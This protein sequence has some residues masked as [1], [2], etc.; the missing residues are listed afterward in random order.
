[1]SFTLIDNE[2]KVANESEQIFKI[3]VGGSKRR[4]YTRNLLVTR[5]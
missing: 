3:E 1:M 5:K 4:F 2:L